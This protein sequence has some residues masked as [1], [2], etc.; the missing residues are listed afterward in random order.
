MYCS[1]LKF[2]N[3]RPGMCCANGKMKL[4]KL[5][6]IPEPISTLVSKH[7]LANIRKYNYMPTLL[8]QGEIYHRTESLLLLPDVDHKFLPSYTKR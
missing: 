4:S 1:A 7:F 5:H 6:L 3:E 8:V 2:K